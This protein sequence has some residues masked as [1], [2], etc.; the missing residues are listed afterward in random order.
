MALTTQRRVQGRKNIQGLAKTR[1][2]VH[3]VRTLGET[4]RKNRRG[5]VSLVHY[6]IAS[7]KTKRGERKDKEH[8]SV[9]C[10]K[11]RGILID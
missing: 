2:S 11:R 1:E 10:G 9:G 4:E 5:G 7:N 6:G 3:A 8:P